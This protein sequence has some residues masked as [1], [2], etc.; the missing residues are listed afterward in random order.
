M[1][2]GGIVNIGVD[3][4]YLNVGSSRSG[5]MRTGFVMPW[6]SNAAPSSAR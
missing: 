6:L 3:L 1:K 5:S 2:L 4:T